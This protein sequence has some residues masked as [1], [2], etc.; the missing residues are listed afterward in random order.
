MRLIDSMLELDIEIQ[1]FLGM[2]IVE[3]MRLTYDVINSMHDDT[4]S[5][6]QLVGQ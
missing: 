1:S 4:E 2:R 6:H 3:C 5:L